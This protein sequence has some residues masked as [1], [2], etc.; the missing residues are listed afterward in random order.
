M[1]PLELL[2]PCERVRLELAEGGIHLI[3]Q[4]LAVVVRQRFV[5]DLLM[6]L[7]GLLRQA[8][9]ELVIGFQYTSS[10]HDGSPVT[11]EYTKESTH[12]PTPEW[13]MVSLGIST[14]TELW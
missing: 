3:E 4:I 14:S 6:L 2:L 13:Y 12:P 1:A 7:P 5:D 9:K 11:V 8:L 10:R